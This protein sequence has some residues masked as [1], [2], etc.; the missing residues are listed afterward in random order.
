MKILNLIVVL[1]LMFCISLEAGWNDIRNSSFTLDN[2]IFLQYESSLPETYNHQVYY[3]LDSEWHHNTVEHL[4]DLTFQGVIPFSNEEILP[5]SF[6]IEEEEDIY[7]IP[8]YTEEQPSE[9]SEMTTLSDYEQNSA[10][11]EH[12]N[13]AGE[14][15]LLAEENLYFAF[16][17]YGGGFPV[18]EGTLGPFYSY[19]IYLWPES[20][21]TTQYVYVLLFT[22]DLP[23]FINPGLFKIN[24][25]TEELLQIGS[26]NYQLDPENNTLYLSCLWDDLASDPDFADAYSPEEPVIIS[27]L[28]QKI[29]DFGQI[30]TI[31]DEGHLHKVF[32]KKYQI[33]PY[34]NT[35]PV[36]DNVDVILNDDNTEI[37]LDYYDAEGHFPL[38]A[39]IELDSGFT[40]PFE[41]ASHNFNEVV[42]YNCQFEV[43]W[44]TATLLFSD[45]GNDIV[46]YPLFNTAVADE[47]HIASPGS[48]LIYPNPFSISGSDNQSIYFRI[49]NNSS[50]DISIYNIRGQKLL[51]KR[52]V[53]ILDEYFSLPG[54][55]ISRSLPSSGIYLVTVVP[56]TDTH[57]SGRTESIEK[58]NRQFGKFLFLK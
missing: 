44:T 42:Q 18:M 9:L 40:V 10:I 7:I 35:L 31:M 17:N 29:E 22:L 41:P 13:I 33:E 52:N 1:P 39:E 49:D 23:P 24:A 12:L 46:E 19:A 45:N 55:E 58:G 2:E 15:M 37:F 3:Y 21:I 6:R 30:V 57:E 51:S 5:L 16:Q 4:S 43:N 25:A 32:L 50:V 48:L 56:K 54:I 8:G 38:I 11:P 53:Q 26:I 14:K 28:T 36:I 27:S 47:L 34:E 20:E